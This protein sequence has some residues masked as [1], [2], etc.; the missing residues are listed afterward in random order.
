MT[1]TVWL[2]DIV[3]HY[4]ISMA[5]VFFKYTD[6]IDNNLLNLNNPFKKEFDHLRYCTLV[7]L[8]YNL[9]SRTTRHAIQLPS[10]S[11]NY[12]V[13]ITINYRVVIRKPLIKSK[14][15]TFVFIRLL[16]PLTVMKH[17]LHFT[18]R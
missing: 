18:K 11:T 12:R 13:A 8:Q 2:L 16:A 5:H 3:R 14:I 6:V 1:I 9:P 4:E 17:A 10:C 15:C 7:L